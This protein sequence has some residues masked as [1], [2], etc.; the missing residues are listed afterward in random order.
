MNNGT[1]VYSSDFVRS[2]DIQGTILSAIKLFDE[3]EFRN[4]IKNNNI[5]IEEVNSEKIILAILDKWPA[6]F[7]GMKIEI[8]EDIENIYWRYKNVRY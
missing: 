7:D 2:I 1:Y 8:D 5:K 4:F 3:S 6:F